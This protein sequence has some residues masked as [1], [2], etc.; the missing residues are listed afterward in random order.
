MRLD[1]II[2]RSRL[3]E[4]KSSDLK[5]ALEELLAVSVAKFP[6]LKPELL[7]RSLLQRE[8]TMTTYLGNG[9]SLPHARVKMARPYV[10]AVGRSKVG[11][12]H[13]GGASD[14]RIHFILM[15]IAGEKARSY[16]PVLASLA[17]LFKEPEFIDSLLIAPDLNDLY[18]KLIAGLGGI[19]GRPVQAQQNRV[20]RLMLREAERIA[21]GA[22]CGAL[23]VFGDTFVGGIEVGMLQPKLKTILVTRNPIEVGDDHSSF[24]ETIQVRSFSK[25]R[26]AQL[27]SA[28]L[29]GLTH[30]II[31][32]NDRVC[33]IGG[34]TG[35]N[36]FD[37]LVVVD[38][39]REFQTLL[40][41]H[42][43]LLP[44]DVRP[45][46]LER[47]IAVA[48]E[49]AVEGREG[50]PV[51]C[52]FVVGDTAKVEKLV[53]PLVLNPFYGYKEEDRNILNPFMDET[54]KEFSLLDGAFIIRGDGVVLSAG[55]LLQATDSE[56]AL[57]SGL[58]SRH[59]AAAAISVASDCIS[60]VVSSSTGQ[61]NLF[62]RG[63]MLP[64]TE[65]KI[66]PG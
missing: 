37:T 59:A 23:M 1:K 47:V 39:E 62:R 17:R 10:L 48:T 40:T 56:H 64:L 18:T 57:P 12:R 49:L 11:I 3:V 31:S 50:R 53:K 2:A 35:S 63:V 25:A 43:E 9:V 7:L 6:D 38:V 22:G 32:F 28:M 26:L 27:R 20:N 66:A 30:G 51:G 55:S 21:K 29:V 36:Q 65:R 13:D 15:L 5:G 8:G 19:A 33:C 58:G 16:L 61:V 41:G 14:E 46:V 52:L 4:L 42:A 34:I 24:A 54:I 45:E 60:I 44:P